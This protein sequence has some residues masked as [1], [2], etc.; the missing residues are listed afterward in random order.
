MTGEDQNGLGVH[1]DVGTIVTDAGQIHSGRGDQFNGSVQHFHFAQREAT[2]TLWWTG[3][4]SNEIAELRASFVKPPGFDRAAEILRRP[5][6]VV[7]LTGEPGV[8]RRAAAKMLLCPEGVPATALRLPTSAADADSGDIPLE[9][10]SAEDR[11]LLDLS[12][13]DE[14]TFAAQQE[15]LGKW[16]TAAGRKHARLVAVLPHR[17]DH[18]L[19]DDLRSLRVQI[20]RP[21]VWAVLGKHLRVAG[22][23]PDLR[24]LDDNAEAT[25][26]QLSM[27]GVARVVTL[28]RQARDRAPDRAAGQWL[29]TALSAATDYGHRVGVLVANHPAAD[30]RTL[31][32]SAAV[33][34][35]AS[36]DTVFF[37]ERDLLRRIGYRLPEDK[38]RLELD[39][40]TERVRAMAPD[41]ELYAN[42][43]I[44]FTEVA[45]GAAVLAHFWDTYPDFRSDLTQWVDHVM[46]LHEIA[47]EDRERAAHRLADQAVRSGRPYLLLQVAKRWTVDRAAWGPQLATAVLGR[48]LVAE[49]TA[50][51]VWDQLYQWS[52]DA[53]VRAELAD[54][55]IELCRHVLAVTHPRPALVR[56][57]WLHGHDTPAVAER[58]CRAVV[59][60]TSDN[61]GL[62]HLVHL[63]GKRARFDCGLFAAAASPARLVGDDDRGRVALADRSLRALLVDSWRTTITSRPEDE[64]SASIDAWLDQHARLSANGGATRVDLLLGALVD[65]FATDMHLLSSLYE[66]NRAW[67]AV[68][69]P[70][71]LRTAAEVEREIRSAVNKAPAGQY[72]ERST[73]MNL[74][75]RKLAGAAVLAVIVFTVLRVAHR[76][77][78]ERAGRGG[79]GRGFRTAAEQGGGPSGARRSRAGLAGARATPARGRQRAAAQCA[80]RLPVPVQRRHPLDRHGGV[81][82]R[83]PRPG[84]RGHGRR[85]AAR[86]PA[87]RAAGSGGRRADDVPA[88]GASEHARE[89]RLRADAGLGIGRHHHPAA[90]GRRAS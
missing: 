50:Y 12:D 34:E 8:G 73:L 63:L 18:V 74:S 17:H 48:L 31:L 54:V 55:V 40:V 80:G 45:F 86:S 75:R 70:A 56:L 41:L 33:F 38:L 61:R 68:D 85:A 1:G 14:P 7:L 88:R 59:D 57:S 36:A 16:V 90:A 11:L 51:V 65:V 89:R 39:G 6:S 46:G 25:I 77:L 58:A 60:L 4:A 67:L 24:V 26:S 62:H 42:R 10:V 21:D 43:Q 32:L 30:Q 76:P 20:G 2:T 49:R 72:N 87:D 27:S 79:P 53:S 35:E 71:R 83:D 5:G 22:V 78:A 23:S 81:R 84:R 47:Q 3:I 52:R 64:W 29:S 37:A 44:R 9:D 13:C 15:W 28:V 66:A 69:R 19:Q 82:R